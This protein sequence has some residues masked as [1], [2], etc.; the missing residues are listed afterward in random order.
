MDYIFRYTSGRYVN[1]NGIATFFSVSIKKLNCIWVF[2]S[3][4]LLSIVMVF[5]IDLLIQQ[6]NSSSIY[7]Y[8]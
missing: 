3:V 7:Q 5:F 8:V 4:L 1:K 6:I 2:P